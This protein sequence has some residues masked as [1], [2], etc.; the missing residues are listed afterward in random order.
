MAKSKP[1][2]KRPARTV[3][4]KIPAE[5]YTNVQ[6]LINGT[7]FRSPTEFAIHVLRDVCAGGRLDPK[8]PNIRKSDLDA[9]H[10]RLRALGYIE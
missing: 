10:A 4:L 6:R 5:L 3:T 1:K 2:S 9:V 7:G 8:A